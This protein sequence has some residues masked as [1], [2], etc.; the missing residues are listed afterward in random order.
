MSNHSPETKLATHTLTSLYVREMDL[1]N[2]MMGKMTFTDTMFYHIMGKHPTAGQTAV[3]DAVLVTLMEHGFTPSVIAARVTYLSAPEALQAAVSAGLLNVASQ[4]VGTMEDCAAILER[5]VMA[6]EGIEAAAKREVIQAHAEKRPLPGFGHHL[7]KPDDPRSP[8]LFEI[9]RAQTE[10][11]GEYL[12]ALLALSSAMDK[13]HGKHLTIHA[14][15]A[16]AAVML[17]IGVP[18]RIMRGFAIIS[19]AVGLVAHI[20]EEQ[21]CPTGRTI[22]K[23]IDQTIPYTGTAN[24]KHGRKR[25]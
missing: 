14:T 12:E 1:V 2:D 22:W 5:L 24:I 11:E 3:L 10:I 4:F 21:E 13:V 16:A 25:G 6:K 19:R 20:M 15:G 7:H 9:A 8:K 23:T 17:E 18:A